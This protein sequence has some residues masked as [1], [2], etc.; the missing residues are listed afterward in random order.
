IDEDPSKGDQESSLALA[1]SS[2]G[3]EARWGVEQFARFWAAPDLSRPS[4]ELAPDIEGWWPGMTRPLRGVAEYARPL[5]KLLARVPD[6]RLEVA[7]HASNGDLIFIR[8]IA[9]GT[10]GGKPLRFTGVDRIRQ[11]NGQVVENRI[12]CDH[13]LVRALVAD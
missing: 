2:N 3:R 5:R 4:N 1:Q 7:E 6:F 13:P 9:H 10:D 12:F 11:K 8:W